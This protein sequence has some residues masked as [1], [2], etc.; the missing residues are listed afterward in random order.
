MR[1][2]SWSHFCWPLLLGCTV[3]AASSRPVVS[4]LGFE[5]GDKVAHFA[6]YGLL[7]TLLCR[8]WGSGWRAAVLA[9]ATAS[10]FGATDEWHQS[11]VPGRDSDVMDWLADSSGAALAVCLYCFWRPYR[12]LLERGWPRRGASADDGP[13]A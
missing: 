12:E 5:G 3:F 10:L 13:V 7:G 11:F 4:G 1:S 8:V 6:V 2:V 9:L